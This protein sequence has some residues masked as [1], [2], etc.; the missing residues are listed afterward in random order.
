MKLFDMHHS[1]FAPLWIRVAIV[2]VAA[3]WA[4][5]EWRMGA[6]HWALLFAAIAL[7]A[8]WSFS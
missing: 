6:P 5:F 8:A 7:Y 3:G 2:L 4:A 1:F